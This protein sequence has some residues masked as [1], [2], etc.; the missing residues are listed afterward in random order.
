MSN[1]VS[2]KLYNAW[3]T[4]DVPRP[5][6]WQARWERMLDG[7]WPLHREK[8]DT[9]LNNPYYAVVVATSF[10][11]KY[12]YFRGYEHFAQTFFSPH[13]K[14]SV[15]VKVHKERTRTDLHHGKYVTDWYVEITDRMQAND[16]EQL[17]R[18]AVGII[19]ASEL[20]RH[21]T[22]L[23]PQYIIDNNLNI[24]LKDNGDQK[25]QITSAG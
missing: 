20:R 18:G 23:L 5:L 25:A 17:Y 21:G 1:A 13:S 15:G 4:P 16:N 14:H 7:P 19:V 10:V 11:L 3:A 22:H 2:T 9:A 24:R 8:Y 6:L 12:G